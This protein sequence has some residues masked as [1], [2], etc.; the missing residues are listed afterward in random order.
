MQGLIYCCV[1]WDGRSNKTPSRCSAVQTWPSLR[2]RVVCRAKSHGGINTLSQLFLRSEPELF[3]S[4][5]R[6]ITFQTFDI[7][8]WIYLH[9]YLLT[10][11]QQRSGEVTSFVGHLC[12]VMFTAKQKLEGKY[13]LLWMS[14]KKGKDDRE[15][16]SAEFNQRLSLIH[17]Y[18]VCVIADYLR[19]DVH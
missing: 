2:E 16:L 17:I 19:A 7:K 14:E 5:S 9:S 10:W 8:K 18:A 6:E 13:T 12:T 3:A 4:E 1:G 15:L 11:L